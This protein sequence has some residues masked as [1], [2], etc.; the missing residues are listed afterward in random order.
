MKFPPPEITR[1]AS[2]ASLSLR[3]TTIC[4][5]SAPSMSD[6]KSD[7]DPYAEKRFVNWPGDAKPSS[8]MDDVLLP[9]QTCNAR[10]GFVIQIPTLPL[11]AMR[12]LSELTDQLFVWNR[13]LAAPVVDVVSASAYPRMFAISR[14][15][16]PSYPR[17]ER[18]PTLRPAVS[19]EGDDEVPFQVLNMR[20]PSCVP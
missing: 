20:V 7:T 14:N 13:R 4:P 19:C 17:K 15:V 3:A 11:W 12:T 6:P 10:S 16:E 9:F 5:L 18:K 2:L 8:R 1:K